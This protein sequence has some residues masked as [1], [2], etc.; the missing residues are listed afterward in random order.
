M[1]FIYFHA[2]PLLLQKASKSTKRQF[3]YLTD[4]FNTGRM[5]YMGFGGASNCF[6]NKVTV[7][8]PLLALP[9]VTVPWP[10]LVLGGCKPTFF[11]G[12]LRRS[13][14]YNICKSMKRVRFQ[15]RVD[16][17]K[18]PENQFLRQSACFHHRQIF[19]GARS[20]PGSTKLARVF[21]AENSLERSKFLRKSAHVCAC[22]N[23]RQTGA[24][25]IA[26]TIQQVLPPVD[27]KNC[28]FITSIWCIFLQ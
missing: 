22:W 6:E 7:P 18:Q 11:L 28:V 20:Y 19:I 13:T 8:G 16:A 12:V 3:A 25:R 10:L 17:S 5:R 27:F 9:G 23:G 14:T 2:T 1:I 4:F 24:A 21:C 26:K 15:D